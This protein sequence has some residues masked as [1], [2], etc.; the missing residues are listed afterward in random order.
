MIKEISKKGSNKSLQ[1]N[2]NKK[3]EKFVD[4]A[5]EDKK[6]DEYLEKD[7]E[8]EKKEEIIHISD[9]E[10]KGENRN[11]KLKSKKIDKKK[12]LKYLQLLP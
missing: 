2:K 12:N 10:E 1:K 4:L 6:I 9:E 3:T 8:E 11:I 7:K 5:L